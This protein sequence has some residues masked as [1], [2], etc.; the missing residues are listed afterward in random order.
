MYIW[1]QDFNIGMPELKQPRIS[2][3]K[4]QDIRFRS[5][6]SNLNKFLESNQTNSEKKSNPEPKTQHYTTRDYRPFLVTSVEP[7]LV[8]LIVTVSVVGAR[9]SPITPLAGLLVVSL[10]IQSIGS[11]VRVPRA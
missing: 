1:K 7:S 10:G 9:M 11:V 3:L 2:Q 5:N 8:P 6:L 4:L